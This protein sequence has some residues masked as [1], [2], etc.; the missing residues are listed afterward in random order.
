MVSTPY[1]RGRSREYA[2]LKMLRDEGWLC[3][4]SAKSHSPVDIFAGKGGRL[5]LIQVKSGS[6]KLTKDELMELKAW[7]EAFGGEAEVWFFKKGGI[8]VR[9]KA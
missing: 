8:V 3:S 2:A 4:R 7:A 6:A 1:S 9:K 5:I